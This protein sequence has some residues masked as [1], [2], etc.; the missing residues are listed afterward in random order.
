VEE[1]AFA[2]RVRLVIPNEV[3]NL[4]FLPPPELRNR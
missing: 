2:L 4:Q 1:S 3:R